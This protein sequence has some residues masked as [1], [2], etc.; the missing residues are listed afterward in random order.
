MDSVNGGV[1]RYRGR[2]ER[3]DVARVG[4]VLERSFELLGWYE[5][6][7]KVGRVLLVADVP[8]FDAPVTNRLLKDEVA[9]ECVFRSRGHALLGG[10]E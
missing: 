9:A 5:L 8:H 7:E 4:G 2:S 6:G 1:E 10:D 3:H